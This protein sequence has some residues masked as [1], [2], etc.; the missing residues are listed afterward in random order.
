V[1]RE[2]LCIQLDT[3]TF[4]KRC[5]RL[6]TRSRS[7]WRRPYTLGRAPG[8]W[9]VDLRKF[10]ANQEDRSPAARPDL[11]L[12]GA[13]QGSVSFLRP[14]FAFCSTFRAPNRRSASRCRR[15]RHLGNPF[16]FKK[17]HYAPGHTLQRFAKDSDSFCGEFSNCVQ[18]SVFFPVS[19]GFLPSLRSH[20]PAFSPRFPSSCCNGQSGPARSHYKRRTTLARKRNMRSGNDCT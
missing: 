8:A 15:C 14:L 3:S 12:P 13:A 6:F 7:L 16:V 10:P 17:R 18:T 19:S 11:R 20:C 4:H 9:Q 2:T 1:R 5:T